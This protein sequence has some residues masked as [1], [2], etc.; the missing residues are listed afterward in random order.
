MVDPRAGSCWALGT[1]PRG[2]GLDVRVGVEV[3][4]ISGPFT[5]KEPLTA[6][7]IRCVNSR[8]Q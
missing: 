3:C 1:P 6:H 5:V 4:E 7:L 8:H 2:G